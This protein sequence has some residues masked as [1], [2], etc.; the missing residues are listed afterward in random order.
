MQHGA[1]AIELQHPPP[2]GNDAV[3]TFIRNGRHAPLACLEVE[4]LQRSVSSHRCDLERKAREAL[5]GDELLHGPHR[6]NS[7]ERFC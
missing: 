4:A 1:G 5:V 6:T 2:G 3:D 7:A